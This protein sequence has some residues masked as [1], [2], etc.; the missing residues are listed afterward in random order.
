MLQLAADNPGWGYR[1]IHGELV[2]LGHP[3]APSTVWLILKRAGVNPAPQ[4]SGPT[5]RQFLATQASTILA[6]DFAH[7]DTVWLTRLYVFFVIELSTRRV[8]L[9]GVTAQP[10]GAW[11][12]Q[13]ARNFFMD[14]QEQAGRFKFLIRDRDS[15]FTDAFDAVFTAE[16]MRILRTPIRAPRANA[17]AERWI[18]SLRRELTDRMLIVSRRQLEHALTVYIDHFNQHRPH[19]SLG[20]TP[21]SGLT[22]SSPP[23]DDVAVVR[24]DRLGGLIHEYE[25]PQVA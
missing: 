16:G 24:R 17:Y 10:D 9:L 19:R 21:P 3:L 18:L 11:V 7:V 12:A 25:Y 23:A 6:C 5:W 22:P 15:R 2:G 1:R 13:C 14:L 20:Q 8:H 4:R